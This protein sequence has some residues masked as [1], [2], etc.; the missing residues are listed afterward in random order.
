[1]S[2][3]SNYLFP[4]DVHPLRTLGLL[5]LFLFCLAIAQRFPKA[6]KEKNKENVSSPPTW[7]QNPSERLNGHYPIV[8]IR[9]PTA[10]QEITFVVTTP[11][12]ELVPVLHAGARYKSIERLLVLNLLNMTWECRKP[13]GFQDEP[14]LDVQRDHEDLETYQH[15][16]DKWESS[17]GL[18][19]IESI[20]NVSAQSRLA[21]MEVTFD[22]S[23]RTSGCPLLKDDLVKNQIH[24]D[25]WAKDDTVHNKRKKNEKLSVE[26]ISLSGVDDRSIGNA[27]VSVDTTASLMSD[28][29]MDRNKRKNGKHSERRER[30]H[31]VTEEYTFGSEFEAAKFQTLVLAMRTIGKE[32]QY[33]Y[34]ALE[35]IY[36]NSEAYSDDGGHGGVALDDAMRC[37][38]DISFV[39]K[40]MDTLYDIRQEDG[41][42][43]SKACIEDESPFI[44][45]TSFLEDE[46][47]SVNLDLERV[48]MY[49]SERTVLGFV[50]F[51]WLLVPTML[52]G[53]PYS[54]PIAAREEEVELFDIHAGGINEHQAR[55]RQLIQLRQRVAS[56]A[57]RVRSYANAMQVVQE[58]KK[59]SSEQNLPPGVVAQRLTFDNV[60]S[61][62]EHDCTSQNECYEPNLLREIGDGALQPAYVL[63]SCNITSLGQSLIGADPVLMV[64]SFQRII[65]ENDKLDFFVV[66]F[67]HHKQKVATLLLYVRWLPTGI[68]SDFDTTLNTYIDS[69]TDDRDQSLYINIS[70]GNRSCSLLSSIF[71]GGPKLG[72]GANTYQCRAKLADGPRTRHFGGLR[73]SR[74]ILLPSNYIAVHCQVN[75]D[76]FSAKWQKVLDSVISFNGNRCVLDIGF[77]IGSCH[78][79]L[80]RT[81]FVNLNS[82]CINPYQ[83]VTP[84]DLNLVDR[85]II[86]GSNNSTDHLG[87]NENIENLKEILSLITVPVRNTSKAAVNGLGHQEITD[88][89]VLQFFTDDELMRHFI[90]AGEDLKDAA[91]RITKCAAF[92]GLTFPIDTRTCQIELQKRQFFHQGSDRN[93]NPV[94][95]F[96]NMCSGLWRQDVDASIAA[97]LYNLENAIQNISKRNPNFKCTLVV[98]MGK[99]SALPSTVTTHVSDS[100]HDDTSIAVDAQDNNT[101]KSALSKSNVA[102]EQHVHTNFKFVQRLIHIVTRNYPERLGQ[103]LVVPNGGWEKLLGTHGLRRYI[104]SPKTRAKVKI[105]SD[106]NSLKDYISSDELIDIAGG[107]ASM[108]VLVS[109]LNSLHTIRE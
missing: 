86:S 14:D 106:L 8:K 1:M 83:E 51:F 84:K 108:N 46:S 47:M 43:K 12:S 41:K 97:V 44:P 13:K 29:I 103:A 16:D 82:P 2:N 4:I 76:L 70:L 104:Q 101:Q 36:K 58:E 6:E 81:R 85:S 100:G 49:K 35:T 91:I 24:I 32:I 62:H 74:K 107:Q 9:G 89:Y 50:D 66:C 15:D 67:T 33:V 37:L 63:V 28:E 11:P 25:N 102:N 55:I 7:K 99:T 93:G 21:T 65:T 10:A 39:R 18:L 73:T 79:Y 38:G 26:G 78:R 69:P 53:T 20:L 90:A 40:R 75:S 94:F 77:Q 95:Y 30:S 92:R 88:G 96:R 5:V 57:V 68:D 54:S 98:L 17:R 105:L 59:R 31:D 52:R 48:H 109:N 19:H 87:A 71:N 34:R 80:T 60:L 22:P 45:T 56:A 3:I 64:P 61:N 27:S 23:K 72:S 42:M